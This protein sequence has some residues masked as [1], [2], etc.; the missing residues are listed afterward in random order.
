MLND[1]CLYNVHVESVEIKKWSV[2]NTKIMV[3]I[4]EMVYHQME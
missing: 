1:F 2:L 3:N 4:I